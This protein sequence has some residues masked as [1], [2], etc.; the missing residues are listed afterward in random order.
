MTPVLQRDELAVVCHCQKRASPVLE[1]LSLRLQVVRLS[2]G[3]KPVT[4]RGDCFHP[5][6]QLKNLFHQ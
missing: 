5:H 2:A 3:P 4:R 1:L 6:F